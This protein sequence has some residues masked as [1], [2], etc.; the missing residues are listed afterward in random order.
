MKLLTACLTLLT[1]AQAHLASAQRSV[2][3]ALSNTNANN[4]ERP[5]PPSIKQPHEQIVVPQ[6]GAMIRRPSQYE[7]T[8]FP[9]RFVYLNGSNI[10]SVRDQELENVTLKIDAQGNIHILAPH[11]EVSQ[12]P[13][14]HP[15]M[16]GELPRFP[17]ERFNID[18]LPQGKYSKDPLTGQS[19]PLEAAAPLAPMAPVAPLAPQASAKEKDIAPPPVPNAAQ[20][21]APSVPQ[22]APA[23]PAPSQP[24]SAQP[25]PAPQGGDPLPE[26]KP[27]R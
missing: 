11:Y 3:E 8:R 6:T 26:N 9:S 21:G 24:G 4:I 17:K 2:S 27:T 19:T 25:A 14:Y 12:D 13:S 18:G 23:Q 22:A 15:L 1:F 16:P 7:T 5:V 10:S 20:Q